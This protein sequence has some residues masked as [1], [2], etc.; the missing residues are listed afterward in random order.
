M[1]IDFVEVC[2]AFQSVCLVIVT[3]R[4]YQS[5]RNLSLLWRKMAM[6]LFLLRGEIARIRRTGSQEF[7]D[8]GMEAS[9][10]MTGIWDQN[11]PSDGFGVDP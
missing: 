2:L 9:D 10:Q 3:F 8:G 1:N 7:L 11:Q 4:L 5:Q 6:E